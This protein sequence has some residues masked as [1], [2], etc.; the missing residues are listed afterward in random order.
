MDEKFK[1]LVSLPV[2]LEETLRR[3][4][5]R[6]NRTRNAQLVQILKERYATSTFEADAFGELCKH[7]PKELS[8]V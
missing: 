5:E 7:K 1:F 2:E 3:E 6:E 8:A 4:A